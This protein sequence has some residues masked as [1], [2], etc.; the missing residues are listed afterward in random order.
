[1]TFSDVDRL[2]RKITKRGASYVAN[3][4][5]ALLSKMFAL[6]M[7]WQYRADNPAKGIERN[8]EEKRE[9]YLSPEELARLGAALAKH[10]DKAAANIFRLLSV[11]GARSGEVRAAKWA[12]FDL[13]AGTWTKPASTTKQ[14]KLHR[15]P[16]NPPARLLLSELRKAAADDAEYLFPG[17]R[18][19]YRV[20]VKADWAAVCKAARIKDARIHDLRHSFASVLASSGHSLPIIGR[21]LGHSQAATTQRYAHLQDDPLRKATDTA[22]AIVTAGNKAGAKIVRFKG[23]RR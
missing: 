17:R 3:R 16:L 6:A 23:G 2:H 4:V 10:K 8:Q 7:R 20:E 21:L 14:A 5:V 11:T 9:R 15:I 22:G 12:D 19:G 1:V 13:E 18:G